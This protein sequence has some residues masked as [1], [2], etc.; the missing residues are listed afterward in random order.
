MPS[1]RPPPQTVRDHS[2]PGF[3]QH[4]NTNCSSLSNDPSFTL[5]PPLLSPPLR[6]AGWSWWTGGSESPSTRPHPAPIAS[7][8]CRRTSWFQARGEPL[9]AGSSCR[10]WLTWPVWWCE[11]P[12]A[13]N[14]VPSTGRFSQPVLSRTKL[15]N[16][17]I[18]LFKKKSVHTKGV[19]NRC[20]RPPSLVKFCRWPLTPS[21]FPAHLLIDTT[22]AWPLQIINP[23]ALRRSQKCLRIKKILMI[24]KHHPSS[25][26][27][28][29]NARWGN[30]GANLT[31]VVNAEPPI[32]IILNLQ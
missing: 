11:P 23:R 28:P 26:A 32:N 6:V 5:P 9:V 17:E 13:Q 10:S 16:D 22:E 1:I 3:I 8:S 21:E 24:L 18:Y 14:T 4:V 31:A 7:F 30:A 12:T 15:M 27:D 29:V 20:S 19:A 2:G 25:D